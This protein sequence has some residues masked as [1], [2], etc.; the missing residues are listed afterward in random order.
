M[1]LQPVNVNCFHKLCVHCLAPLL[2][3]ANYNDC[4]VCHAQHAQ[5]QRAVSE[6]ADVHLVVLSQA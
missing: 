3:F 6:R 1:C 4:F 5:I 2:L